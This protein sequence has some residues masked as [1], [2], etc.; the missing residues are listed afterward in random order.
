MNVKLCIIPKN[1]QSLVA[2][3]SNRDINPYAPR[4]YGNTNGEFF[5][6]NRKNSRDINPLIAMT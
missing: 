5:V 2:S 6:R 1:S 4:T 3:F